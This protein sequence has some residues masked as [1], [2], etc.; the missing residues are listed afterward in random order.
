M[1]ERIIK[2]TEVRGCFGLPIGISFLQRGPMEFP[3]SVTVSTVCLAG[4][5]LEDPLRICSP[6][7]GYESMVFLDG[8]TFFSVFSRSYKT[9]GKAVAGHR[10]IVRRLRSGKLPLAIS[11][12]YT[13]WE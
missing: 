8:C 7:T 3:K 2:Q 4:A 10:S 1:S 6:E 11:L 9:R 12:N 5:H 13:T